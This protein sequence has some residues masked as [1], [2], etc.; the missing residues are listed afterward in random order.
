[1]ATW[2]L[3]TRGGD[4]VAD[5]CAAEVDEKTST[6]LNSNSKLLGISERMKIKAKAVTNNGEKS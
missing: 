3:V 4:S 2:L 6:R 5:K 1:M